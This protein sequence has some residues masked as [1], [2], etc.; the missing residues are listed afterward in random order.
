MSIL[1]EYAE[2][3]FLK[4]LS[5]Y[6]NEVDGFKLLRLLPDDFQDS[7]IVFSPGMYEGNFFLFRSFIRNFHLF[8]KN[9]IKIVFVSD[10]TDAM[11]C[12]VEFMPRGLIDA[13]KEECCSTYSVTLGTST[14]GS[15]A[16]RYAQE[17]KCRF[18]AVNPVVDFHKTKGLLSDSFDTRCP[19][20]NHEI[21]LNQDV[22]GIAEYSKHSADYLNYR[23]LTKRGFSHMHIELI[24][25]EVDHR[26]FWGTDT[27]LLLSKIFELKKLAFK[28]E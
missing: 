22:V 17:V 19:N 20:E 9:R 8:L 13:I 18:L 21:L 28:N 3:L 14:G 25:S 15:A 16:I 7:L 4:E 23:L 6:S 1:S 26:F 5:D 24:E 12:R 2:Q 27:S 10:S 11:F